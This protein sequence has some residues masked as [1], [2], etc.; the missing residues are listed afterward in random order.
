MKSKFFVFSLLVLIFSFFSCEVGLGESVDTEPPKIEVVSPSAGSIVRDKFTISGTCSDEQKVQSV[1]VQLFYIDEDSKEVT[2]FPSE[3]EYYPGVV[4]KKGLSWSC[5]IDPLDKNLHIPDGTYEICAR[6]TDKSGRQTTSKKT[7]SIDNTPPLVILTRPSTGENDES[8]DTYGQIFSIEGKASD[9]S[10]IDLIEISIYD[11]NNPSEK[12]MTVPLK[13]VP[14]SVD[15]T[16]AEFMADDGYYSKIYGDD[17]DAGKKDYF[18]TITSYDG[19]RKLPAEKD[20]K[21]NKSEVYYL[22]DDIA[23][24][25][26]SDFKIPEVYKILQGSYK[27]SNALQNSEEL[28][29][30]SSQNNGGGY[31]ENIEISRESSLSKEEEIISILKQNEIKKGY[32]SLNPKNNPTYVLSGYEVLSGKNEDFENSDYFIS[33][34]TKVSVRISYG[35]DNTPLIDDTLSVCAYEADENQNP[36]PESKV[37]LIPPYKDKNGNILLTEEELSERKKCIS[38]SGSSRLISVLVKRSDDGLT[39]GKNYILKAEGYDE[40]KNEPIVENGG[41]YGFHLSSSG[42]SPSFS[43]EEPSD[44]NIYVNQDGK[45]VLKGNAFHE[46]GLPLVTAKL[47]E[48]TIFSKKCTDF[49]ENISVKDLINDGIITKPDECTLYKLKVFAS[50]NGLDSAEIERNVFY[51][52]DKPE[53]VIYSVTPVV[54]VSGD[55]KK[56]VNGKI[57]VKAQITDGF[58]VIDSSKLSY[59]LYDGETLVD[60][61]FVNDASQF[62]FT[63]DTNSVKDNAPLDLRIKS[64][65][66]AG[67]STEYSVKADSSKSTQIGTESYF[68]N[69]ESDKP[70]IIA[71]SKDTHAFVK[72]SVYTGY[73]IDDDE[74]DSILI[75]LINSKGEEKKLLD[76][77]SINSTQYNFSVNF[78]NEIDDY[79]LKIVAKDKKTDGTEVKQNEFLHSLRIAGDAPVLDVDDIRLTKYITVSG[80]GNKTFELSGTVSGESKPDNPLKITLLQ[81]ETESQAQEIQTLWNVYDDYPSY[82]GTTVSWNVETPSGFPLAETVENKEQHFYLKAEDSNGIS[83]VKECKFLIDNEKPSIIAPKGEVYLPKDNLFKAFEGTF[84]DNVSKI[85]QVYYSENKDSAPSEWK[86]V[87][88]LITSQNKWILNYTADENDSK[89]EFYF[90]AVDNAGN[91][92]VSENPLKIIIDKDIPSITDLKITSGGKDFVSGNDTVYVKSGFTISGKIIETNFKELKCSGE[93]LSVSDG[94]F[95]KEVTEPQEESLQ[96]SYTFT[97][98]DKAGQTSSKS[99]NVFY[100]KK[101]PE[102]NFS[103]VSP[104]VTADGKENNVNGI[105]YLKGT[106]SDNDKVEKTVLK[107]YEADENGN[108][109]ENPKKE[110]TLESSKITRFDLEIDSKDFT[111]KR[112]LKLLLE[113]TDRAGNTGSVE[114]ELFVNQETDKPVLSSS[115]A[116]LDSSEHKENLFGMGSDKIYI[117]AQ[118]DDGIKSVKYKFDVESSE[119]ELLEAKDKNSVLISKEI[120]LPDYLTFGEHSVTITV[121]DKNDEPNTNTVSKTVKFAID[122][123]VPVLSELK[124]NSSPY[125]R[126]MFVTKN[127]KIS[128]KVTDDPGAVEISIKNNEN[129]I[130]KLLN[131]NG[132]FETEEIQ[133]SEGKIL[134]TVFAVDKYGRESSS[135]LDFEIDTTLPVFNSENI[136]L[137]GNVNG[138]TREIKLSE[139]NSLNT[140]FTLSSFSLTGGN[141]T[142]SSLPVTETNLSE[143]ILEVDKKEQTWIPTLKDS[144]GNIINNFE[145]TFALSDGNNTINLFAVDKAGNKANYGNISINVDTVNPTV[146]VIEKIADNLVLNNGQNISFKVSVSDETSKVSKILIGTKSGFSD[147]E[148]IKEIQAIDGEITVELSTSDL[149]SGAKDGNYTLYVRALDNAQNKSSDVEAGSFILDNTCPSVKISN[150]SSGKIVNKTILISG[151]VKDD[152]LSSSALPVLYV[153][154]GNNFV[155]QSQGV[156]DKSFNSADSSWSLKLDTTQIESSESKKEIQIQVGFIDEARNKSELI[157]GYVLNIEQNS[158]RPVIKFNDLESESGTLKKYSNSISGNIED[159]DGV[160]ELKISSSE[161]TLDQWRALQSITLSGNA[162][163]Y[164]PEDSSDGKKTLYFYVKDSS[165]SEFYTK[166]SNSLERPYVQFTK[167]TEKFDNNSEIFYQTDSTPPQISLISA[168][169]GKTAEEALSNARENMS[170]AIEMSSP[171]TSG[172]PDFRYVVYALKTSDSNGIKSVSAKDSNSSDSLNFTESQTETG[173]YYSEAFDTSA[174]DSSSSLNL[175]LNF[176]VQDNSS[177]ETSRQKTVIYSNVPPKIEVTSPKS[178]DLQTGNKITLSG[179]V[180]TSEIGVSVKSVYYAVVNNELKAKTDEELVSYMKENGANQQNDGSVNQ[181]SFVFDGIKNPLLPQTDSELNAFSEISHTEDGIYTL[182]VYVLAVDS[183][184]NENLYKDFTMKYNPFSDRPVTEI[185]YPEVLQ[186]ESVTLSGAMRISGSAADNE[187]VSKVY[188]QI[189]VNNDGQFK[190]DDKTYLS[191]NS[192]VIKDSSSVTDCSADTSFWGIEAKGTSSWYITINSGGE[193][194]TNQNS[195]EGERYQIKVRASSVDNNGKLGPWSSPVTILID[196]KAPAIGSSVRPYVENADKTSKLPYVQDMYLSGEWYFVTSVEDNSGID[197]VY[198]SQ[199]VTENEFSEKIS[200]DASW[201]GSEIPYDSGSS[202]YTVRIPLNTTTGAGRTCVK[203]TAVEKSENPLSASSVYSFKYDNT[204]PSIKDLEQNDVDFTNDSSL[205]DSNMKFTLSGQVQD[206]NSGFSRVLFY[207]AKELNG[208]TYILDPMIKNSK[209]EVTSFSSVL[210]GGEKLYALTENVTVISDTQIS[211]PS[212]SEHIRKGSIVR[213][214]KTFHLIEDISSNTLTISPSMVN[215]ENLSQVQADFI[216]AQVVDNTNPE[217]CSDFSQEDL[218]IEGDDGDGMVEYVSVSGTTWEWKATVK[219]NNMTDGPVN[220]VMFAFDNSGNFSSKKVSAVL[221]NNAPKVAKLHLGTDLNG[222]SKYSAFEF[223]TYDLLSFTGMKQSRYEFASKN[224]GETERNNF[225]IKSNLAIIPEIT[226]GNGEIKLSFERNYTTLKENPSQNLKSVVENVSQGISGDPFVLSGADLTGKETYTDSDDGIKKISFTFWDQTEGLVQGE[227]SQAAVIG[228]NDLNLDLTDGNKPESKILPFYWKNKNDNSLYENS[229]NNGHIELE[230]DLMQDIFKDSSGLYDRDPKVSGKITFRGKA[231]DDV[232]LKSL[233]MKFE[234]INDNLECVAEFDTQTSTWNLSSK[235]MDAD[236]WEVEVLT[237]SENAFF[238]QS[239]HQVEWILSVDTEKI[240]GSAALDKKFIFVSEDHNSNESVNAEYKVDVVPY[241]V[242]VNRESTFNT[243]RARSGAVPLMTGSSDNFIT[244]F[245]LGTTVDKNPSE[246]EENRYTTGIFGITNDKKGTDFVN[247]ANFNY[248]TVEEPNSKI[249]FRIRSSS[250]DGYVTLKV[251]GI[252][253]LN[254]VNNNNAEYNKESLENVDSTKFWTDDRF[255]RIWKNDDSDY[256]KG[257]SRPLDPS[258]DISANGNLYAAYCTTGVRGYYNKFGAAESS[259]VPFFH[260]YDEMAS[261]DICVTGDSKV[262]VLYLGNYYSEPSWTSNAGFAGGVY[263][264]DSDAAECSTG[265]S[266]YPTQRF[267]L[268]YHNELVG[269]FKNLRMRRSSEGILHVAYYDSSTSS[270]H[271]SETK[272]NNKPSNNNLFENSWVNID[273]LTDDEFDGFDKNTSLTHT[274]Q[275]VISGKTTTYTTQFDDINVC[276]SDD[277]FLTTSSK[278]RSPGTGE[279]L[280][281]ALT[282]KQMPVIVYSDMNSTMRIA[283]ATSTLPKGASGGNNWLIQDAMQTSDPNYSYSASSAYIACEIDSSGYLHIAFQNSKGELVYLKSTNAPTNGNT[284]YTFG[285]SVVLCDSAMDIDIYLNGTVPYISYI[286]KINT[287]DGLNMAF[288]DSSLDLDQDGS[289]EGAW[290]TMTVPLSRRVSDSRT[291]VC[292]NPSGNSNKWHAAIGFT[293]GDYYRV[294]FYK[295]KGN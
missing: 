226:G 147:S 164:S 283:R 258:M 178:S 65:D 133:G 137:K 251:N 76:K 55:S 183:L 19:A 286:S 204:A 108:Y 125:N 215:T 26:L 112:K 181:F 10:N 27:F 124:I 144:S 91:Y 74:I 264:Y 205:F 293:P 271:Y 83:T 160:K 289:A 202:G 90:K 233:W 8:F 187:S 36:I 17:I 2:K 259:Q 103:S 166:S 7:F 104:L 95:T 239:G 228:I 101:K 167:N 148:K 168:G 21:G 48:K 146:S 227:T 194:Q 89:K 98:S 189:D 221:R 51:D 111:D 250:I 135:E 38:R 231:F 149:P 75:S 120:V 131:V 208:E 190:D 242:S 68:V 169:S 41:K 86:A 188:I 140:W 249:S 235:T 260:S 210:E 142:S 284:A 123:N 288:F 153:Y 28:K 114:K 105:V 43:L 67:N 159:D 42:A 173:S 80:N 270:I 217:N 163:I 158:D 219:S 96:F 150:P 225:T 243:N 82:S 24:S 291:C 14:P 191:A 11:K 290:E 145:G 118:D 241:I 200:K 3:N 165:D 195:I 93:T 182:P 79:T 97:V 30:V 245:N 185:L 129:E 244:G 152:N 240:S 179:N 107:C 171:F 254:N 236:G 25:V 281:I 77:N 81:G 238:N 13:N 70:Q 256:F 276:V 209:V 180:S 22:Y 280:G 157:K 176:T 49:S 116:K 127:Y 15:L 20:D 212:V 156:S 234:G 266:S 23:S 265:R 246:S 53:I 92:S 59:L 248:A 66:K 273:G 294:A 199:A 274:H 16:V 247:D 47:G 44:V 207:F 141:K 285:E 64:Y 224:Y 155:E 35:I 154:D 72:G 143:I 117:T 18:C 12:I 203:I 69:Q 121:S 6:A 60:E 213:I 128:G 222:D 94:T 287:T 29:T 78:P 85:S 282:S 4:D 84:T 174:S 73:V 33:S 263:C 229:K 211:L 40:N 57:N 218:V 257:S 161:K 214:G 99:V 34:G 56:Y 139:Y 220:F 193:L 119:T 5:T 88:S 109:S 230:N 275:T 198:Y 63:V 223:E 292:V 192:Y 255:V 100:D 106:S 132:D 172:G 46:E 138:N 253:T 151:T 62:N 9:V 122:R 268:L 113:S 136:Y 196:P 262:N 279:Y 39:V 126:G 162:F 50:Y 170:K 134:L 52:I 278:V 232:R 61:V 277:K 102:P 31:N 186:G 267:E 37:V 272:G 175:T 58:G 197:D 252:S 71:N 45:F 184:G 295:G 115:N 54:T 32:F 269:Q 87:T 237:D 1:E 261:T 206:D 216:L 130:K 110:I 177:L 201:T